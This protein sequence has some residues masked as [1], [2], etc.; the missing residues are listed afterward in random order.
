MKGRAEG[1]TSADRA[2]LSVF[3][4]RAIVAVVDWYQSVVPA[5]AS[6]LILA[7]GSLPSRPATLQRVPPA[8]GSARDLALAAFAEGDRT[9]PFT[10][11]ES[12]R[13]YFDSGGRSV[14]WSLVKDAR[15]RILSAADAEARAVTKRLVDGKVTIGKW[16]T[17]IASII[18]LAHGAAASLT[19]GGWA[20]LDTTDWG[21]VSGEL[22]FQYIY[23]DGFASELEDE[24][25]PIDGRFWVRVGQY[26]RSLRKTWWRLTG[27]ELIKK[28]YDLEMNILGGTENCEE[29]LEQSYMGWV[30]Q[31]TLIDIGERQCLNYCS[32]EIQYASSF[33]GETWKDELID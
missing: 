31:G 4:G 33:T 17:E 10:W 12:L 7:S 27:D 9:P 13:F 29:C 16:Q 21:K 20:A 25:Y 14:S 6:E 28:G 19:L 22:D 1:W 3:D 15:D 24:A 32:C 18:K 23:L 2:G 8:S 30:R 26:P 5:P 11:S